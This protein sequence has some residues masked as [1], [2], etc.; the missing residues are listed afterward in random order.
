MPPGSSPFN[1]G[2]FWLRATMVRVMKP[3]RRYL[4]FDIETA[5]T[6]KED[7]HSQRPL[8][9]SCAA[10]LLTGADQ[11]MLWHGG[12]DRRCPADRLSREES[13]ALVRYLEDQVAQGFTLLTWNG[14]GFDLD[15]LQEESGLLEPC[16]TLARSHVDMIFHAFCTLGHGVGL[17]AA[18]RG[19]GLAGKIKGIKGADAPVLWAQGRREE[20]LRYVAQDVR[21]TLEL[22]RACEGCGQL[23]WVSRSG[24]LRH[25]A[26]QEGWLTVEEA[27]RLPLPDTSWMSEPWPREKF[28]E[29]M[30]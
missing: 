10:T 7:W 2:Q 9:I 4:A 6:A 8:G 23:R 21:T 29:W 18:A 22:A 27:P 25:M 16:R 15:V 26:L 17:D 11:A 5:S 3:I 13:A 28:T 14:L 1:S 19:M 30:G 12:T 24:R 20:V